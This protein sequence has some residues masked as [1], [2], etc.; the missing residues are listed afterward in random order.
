MEWDSGIRRYICCG[1]PA[2]IKYNE[3]TEK[4]WWKCNHC[5]K[6]RHSY[7]GSFSFDKVTP[8]VKG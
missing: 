7:R 6:T 4:A 2:L 3:K 5:G 1:S 8:L